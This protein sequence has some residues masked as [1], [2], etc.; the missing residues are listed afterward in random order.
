M[1]LNYDAGIEN[2]TLKGEGRGTRA[3]GKPQKRLDITTYDY[4][5]LLLSLTIGAVKGLR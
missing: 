4:S 5:R 1:E 2:R 3:L